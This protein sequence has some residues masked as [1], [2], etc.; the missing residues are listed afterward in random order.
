MEQARK[1]GLS[2]EQIQA[3]LREQE[4]FLDSAVSMADFTL[5]LSKVNKSV[6][7]GDLARYKEWMEEFGSA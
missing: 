6:G 2:R 1:E 7:E 4:K 3:R 5:A